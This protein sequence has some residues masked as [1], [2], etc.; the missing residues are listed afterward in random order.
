ME[1]KFYGQ[2]AEDYIMWSLFPGDYKGTFVDVG[3]FDGVYFSNTLSFEKAGWSGVCI[4]AHPAYFRLLQKNR[5]GSINVNAAVSSE[6][7]DSTFFYT[8]KIGIFSSLDKK[9]EHRFRKKFPKL[10]TGYKKIVVPMVTLN[11]LLEKNRITSI[12]VLSVDV[13]GTDIEVL[14]G[15][16]IKK[17]SP[18]V[19]VIEALDNERLR[20]LKKYFADNEYYYARQQ[21]GNHFFCSHREDAAT[22]YKV[23]TV[24][25][26]GC[27]AKPSK[28]WESANGKRKKEKL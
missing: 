28:P 18:R 26:R 16:S 17:Y 13:E 6:D 20:V 10:F 9:E 19:V 27:M 7:K 8:S 22:I 4:E 25:A 23:S 24:G 5:P 3:A 15:L 14:K 1:K 11:S 2:Q 12:D 21:N